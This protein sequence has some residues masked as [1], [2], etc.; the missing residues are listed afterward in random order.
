M[1]TEIGLYVVAAKA[2][3]RDGFQLSTIN[4]QAL[5][6]FDFACFLS[7]FRGYIIKVLDKSSLF[8]SMEVLE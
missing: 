5:P 1:K 8:S 6:P 4:Y 2:T 3:Q 7:V